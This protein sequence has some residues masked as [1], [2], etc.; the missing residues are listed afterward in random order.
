MIFS[1]SACKSNS[2]VITYVEPDEREKALLNM[3]ADH[4]FI[5]DY[6]SSKEYKEV[7]IWLEKYE[8][9]DLVNRDIQFG[10][11][12][13]AEEGSIIFTT[14]SDSSNKQFLFNIGTINNGGITSM[15]SM[16]DYPDIESMASLW[17]TFY[18]ENPLDDGE[19]ILAY[20]LY[21]GAESAFSI[22]NLDFIEGSGANVEELKSYAV[23]YLLKAEFIE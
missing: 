3:L 15:K 21:D 18:E 5:F 23:T 8:N 1:L 6:V 7:K 13:V 12:D 19:I 16:D 10:H 9:G 14:T 2:N 20:I 17:G 4:Y 11:F 22:P